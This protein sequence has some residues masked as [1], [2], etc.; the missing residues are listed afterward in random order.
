V[1]YSQFNTLAIFESIAQAPIWEL[2][3]PRA[4]LPAPSRR[5]R[6]FLSKDLQKWAGLI[7]FWEK[8][9]EKTFW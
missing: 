3:V 8:V 9:G 6:G 2:V 7:P 1:T 5:D 4:A